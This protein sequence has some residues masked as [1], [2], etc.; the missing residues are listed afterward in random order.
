MARTQTKKRV[1]AHLDPRGQVKELLVE[2]SDIAKEYHPDV[3]YKMSVEV[4]D[5]P[6]VKV[7]WVR[8]ADGKFQQPAP[9][10]ATPVQ[11][12]QSA[13]RDGVRVKGKRGPAT[14]FRTLPEDWARMTEVAQHVSMF[15]EFPGG[16]K[17]YRWPSDPPVTFDTT[18]EFLAAFKAVAAWRDRWNR[19]AD[20]DG[21]VPPAEIT[22]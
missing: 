2:R 6:Q 21:E 5:Q 16:A 18:E 19:Y 17:T 15:Q 12:H 4:T 3:L 11:L 22:A 9:P 8:G 1:F 20:G 13:L 10:V 7:G 14:K